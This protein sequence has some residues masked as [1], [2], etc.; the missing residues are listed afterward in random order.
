MKLQILFAAF[1][2]FVAAQT[3]AQNTVTRSLSD[4]DQIDVSGGF[5]K[6]ILKE[7]DA[8]AVDLV[9]SGIDAD[10]I[11]TEVKGKSLQIGMKNGSYR[12]F[13]AT[14]TVTY[15]KLKA[16]NN[17]GST[18]IETA[19]VLRGDALE[20]N[21]SG[22]GDVRCELA[23]QKLEVAI[24]GSSNMKFSGTADTQEID[25]SGSG[26]IDASKLKGKSAKVAISG[27]GNVRLNIDGP[28]R[29]SVSGSGDVVNQ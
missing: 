1:C 17:S 24:S 21:F 26:D 10:K 7:G 4:F 9:V 28:V 2:L 3:Q 25:V 18:N 11:I 29:S 15:R 6:V 23:V 14:L 5:D 22:S 20:F 13:K 12:S 19:S 8:P 27:S 16:I